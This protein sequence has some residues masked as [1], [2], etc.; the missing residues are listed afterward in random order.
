MLNALKAYK[1]ADSVQPFG[2]F[3][4]YTDV[5]ELMDEAELLS[6]LRD[7]NVEGVQIKGLKPAIEDVFID[8]MKEPD[9]G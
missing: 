9:H 7:E 8:L 2:E 6:Y 4:H 1:Y 5:R 3:V